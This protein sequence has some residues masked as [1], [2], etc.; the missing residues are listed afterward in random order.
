MAIVPRGIG[1]VVAAVALAM[2][3]TAPSAA[4]T[5]A[6]RE[7]RPAVMKMEYTVGD[8]NAVVHSPR[9]LVGTLPL[10]FSFRGNDDYAQSLAQQGSV[11]VLVSDRIAVDRHRELWRQLSE[12][13]GPLVERFRGFAGHFAVAEP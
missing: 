8:L 4:A 9:A 6:V 11:V 13:G 10:V 5:T 3:L 2:V 12:A 7:H 1:A